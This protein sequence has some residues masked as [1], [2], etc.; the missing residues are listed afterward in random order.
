M[1]F[2]SIPATRVPGQYAEFAASN[3]KAG[4]STLNYRAILLGQATT[5]GTATA[6]AIYSVPD[7][8]TAQ[9]LFGLGSMLHLMAK[10]FFAN[11]TVSEL[12]A[13]VTQKDTV[14]S[15]TGKA[16]GSIEITAAATGAGSVKLYVDGNRIEALVASGD[17]AIAIATAIKTKIDAD[18]PDLP[19]KSTRTDDTIAFEALNVGTLGNFIDIRLNY[20]ENEVL[21]A[22]VTATITAMS[23]GAGDPDLSAGTPSV[24]DN[25]QDI[26]YQLFVNPYTDD[27]N[28]AALDVELERRFGPTTQIDGVSFSAFSGSASSI[29]E[30]GAEYNS[31]HISIAGIT[32]VMEQPLEVASAIA[33]QVAGSLAVGNG[34]E[35]VPFQTLPLVGIHAPAESSRFTFAQQDAFLKGGIS[36]LMVDAGGVVRIQRLITTYQTNPS[37]G[38]DLTWLDVNTR[39]T[40]M[41]IRYDWVNYLKTKYPRAKLADDGSAVGAGQVIITP[42]IARAEAAARFR[43]WEK[44]GLV[45]NFDLFKA[46]LIAERDETDVNAMN[47]F[48]PADFV[49][50][51]IVGKTQIGVIL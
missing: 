31:K 47:W 6:K 48:L 24:I 44:A 13:I 51:F 1:Q 32:D 35:S 19:V 4:L 16:T 5:A 41:F 43:V 27:T 42:K 34:A 26:W 12:K 22:G 18:F 7:E 49:N 10:R 11:N 30:L 29:L 9:T 39:F 8:A 25:L 3:L 14:G 37:G 2:T 36:T 15:P 20:G 38:V 23:G 28:L 17:T 45:E 40:A 46:N 33:G 21:P 50:Q